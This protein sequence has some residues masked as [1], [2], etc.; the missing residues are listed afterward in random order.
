MQP[1]GKNVL[2]FELHLWYGDIGSHQMEIESGAPL[3]I[4]QPM[5]LHANNLKDASA[6]HG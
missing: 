6:Y 4:Q 2:C 1:Y 3:M 5:S